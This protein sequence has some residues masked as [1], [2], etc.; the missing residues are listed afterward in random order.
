M[1]LFYIENIIYP[2][3]KISYLNEEVNCTELPPQLVF[4]VLKAR[5]KAFSKSFL[6]LSFFEPK[7]ISAFQA[8]QEKGGGGEKQTQLDSAIERAKGTSVGL[9]YKSFAKLSA[10]ST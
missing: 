10:L 6:I 2:S 5:Q 9:D 1:S 4:P 7:K 3:Y 8:F